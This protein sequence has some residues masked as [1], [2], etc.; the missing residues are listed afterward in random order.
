MDSRGKTIKY[1]PEVPEVLEYLKNEGIP[2]AVASRTT[3]IDGANQLIRL[4]KW[5]KYFVQ[6]EIYPGCKLDHFKK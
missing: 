2:I 3:E 5:E 1:F 6:K 4:F